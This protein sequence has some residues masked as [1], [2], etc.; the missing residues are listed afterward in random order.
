MWKLCN[1]SRQDTR[2][3][4]VGKKFN[5]ENSTVAYYIRR[6]WM[7]LSYINERLLI[8]VETHIMNDS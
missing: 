3:E 6:K 2:K 7:E 4:R 5:K 8:E 1:K